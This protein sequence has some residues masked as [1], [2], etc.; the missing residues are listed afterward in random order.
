MLGL[1]VLGM[2]FVIDKRLGKEKRPRG[3]LISS[4]FVMYF[5]GRF[6]VEFF[7]E[8]DGISP[9]S[10]L[11]MGQ[12]LSLPGILIGV[13]GLYWSFTKRVPVG[14]PHEELPEGD[15]E[16]EDEDGDEDEDEEADGDED[17]D[18]DEESKG[19]AES[20]DADSEDEEDDAP[21]KTKTRVKPKAADTDVD[22]EF[23][24]QGRLKRARD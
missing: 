12:I 18:G 5:C 9:D 24:E 10:P 14:W 22:S 23:D 19:E 2:L 17:E 13:Y 3:A 7:K 8:Y 6:I 15:D 1:T 4:F 11:R 16:E 20:D 21:K